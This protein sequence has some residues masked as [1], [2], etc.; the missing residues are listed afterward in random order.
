MITPAKDD[1][2]NDDRTN[3]TLNIKP[4]TMFAGDC[5]DIL[6]GFNDECIDLVYLDPPF[7]SNHN[8]AAPIGSE[9]AGAAF[10]DTW[11]LSDINL[12]WHG[13]IKHDYPG[14]YALLNAVRKV[15]S[16]S[17]MSYLIYMAVR[18]VEL[19]RVIKT[20]GSI[21]LHFDPTAGHYLKLLMDAIFGKENF[22]NEIIWR[23]GW[24]SGFKTQKIRMDP[25]PRRHPLLRSFRGSEQAIQQRIHTIPPG[26]P[27][28]GRLASNGKRLSD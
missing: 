19:K 9:A 25:Q 13:L 27:S 4:R 8:Y 16:D 12:A 23:I 26:I 10:K 7:N 2:A 21:Y 28:A 6:R 15:H 3:P 24:V 1:A 22:R 20:T 14:L 17:M 18:V 5:L 11:S